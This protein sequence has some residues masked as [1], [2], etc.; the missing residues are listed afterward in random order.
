MGSEI[1]RG[2]DRGLFSSPV[3]RALCACPTAVALQRKPAAEGSSRSNGDA[4][5]FVPQGPYM[6][7]YI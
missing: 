1:F 3:P 6:G 7:S 2:L 4:G 5:E